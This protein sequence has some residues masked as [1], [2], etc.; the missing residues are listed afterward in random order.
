MFSIER[1]EA[2]EEE[3]LR[4]QIFYNLSLNL[5]KPFIYDLIIQT[6]AMETA[7]LY[8]FFLSIYENFLSMFCNVRQEAMEEEELRQQVFFYPSIETFYL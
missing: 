1:Q 5:S 8:C 4:Q 6:K 3:E 2:I 7:G